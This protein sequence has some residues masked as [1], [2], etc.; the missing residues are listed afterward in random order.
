V[1]TSQSVNFGNGSADEAGSSSTIL[2]RRIGEAILADGPMTF[3]DFMDRAL[4]TPG[5][6]YYARSR[7][8][9]SVDSDFV[10][11]P[12]VDA[13]LGVA[14]ARLAQECDAALGSPGSFDL[15][16]MGGGD[17][18]LLRDVCDALERCAPGV[19]ARTR[20]WSIE[21]G[22]ASRAQQ[23]ERLAAHARRVQWVASLDELPPGSVYGL[24]VSNELLDAFPVHR[25]VW[26]NGLRELF[27]DVDK[28]G[29]AFVE[30]ELA[31]S[32]PELAGYFAAND[33]S[34]QEGQA[35]E[36]SL[37]VASWVEGVARSL[38]RGLVLTVDYGA[39]T[40][41]LYDAAR[42]H[43]SLVCQHRYQLN[44]AP[45]ER[46]GEQD[47]TAHVDFGNLRRCGAANGLDD[48][49]L[50]SLAVFLVGFGAADDL[51]PPGDGDAVGAAEVRRHLG[52][53]HLLFSEIGDAHRVMLQAKGVAPVPF[54]LSRLG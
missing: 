14:V 31:P 50:A 11:A 22:D 29:E 47:I 34:L 5:E 10:T 36:V 46:I 49:G 48:G 18:A 1:S 25:V 24:M 26:R 51:A 41:A 37:Q 19:Y 44:A 6:G 21:P 45:Y 16:E 43:G 2:A 28:D 3:R 15:V 13:S 42:V 53:R 20:V 33:I 12:Q 8:A 27:V 39:E 32:T 40:A 52:L 54:G 35:A 38:A 30:R 9:W 4:Y 17:G 23:Q 7:T